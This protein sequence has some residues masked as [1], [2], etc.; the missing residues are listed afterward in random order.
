VLHAAG[1]ALPS[2]ARAVGTPVYVYVAESLRE[3]FRAVRE[4][5]VGLDVLAC[6]SVKS[7]GNLAVLSLL[8]AEGAGFDVVS[9]GELHRVLLAGGDP[10][11]VVF[12]GVGKTDEDLR[13]ALDVGVLSI[14]VES[15]GEARRLDRIA[16]AR[17]ARAPVA[18]RVNP[19]IEARTHPAVATGGER[20]KFGMD[21]A[22]V[23][24]VLRARWSNLEIAGLHA[25]VGSQIF[26]VSTYVRTLDR[27]AALAGSFREARIRTLDLGGGFGADPATGRTLDLR[28]LA[29]AIAPRMR[30]LGARLVL[31][32]GRWVSG[33]SGLLLTRVLEVKKSGRRRFV[34]VDAGMNDFLR[35]ALYDAFH[36]I[37]P[38]RA[39]GGRARRYDVVGPVCET[40]DVLGSDRPLVDP[41]PGDLLALLH[42]GAYGFTMASNYNGRPRPAEVLAE[43]KGFRVVRERESLED[44]VRGEVP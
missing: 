35:P 21:L 43:G 39:R 38:V 4:A 27:L 22:S 9:A 31:E 2:L 34:V 30:A 29:G 37:V 15:E 19:G 10:S 20:A 7:N 36:P 17:D 5:F 44:L 33:P 18:L 1:V 40:G 24:R 25:H 26:E 12:A 8:A 32:P 28:D 3:R 11:K 13:A 42:A 23:L 41:T 16:R 6:Y 14:Q